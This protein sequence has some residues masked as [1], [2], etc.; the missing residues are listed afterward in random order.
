MCPV[1]AELGSI[2]L[3][4][5]LQSLT[6]SC[7][8][9][10]DA[11]LDHLKA[12]A[13]RTPLSSLS[14][15]Q[16]DM[17]A[18]GLTTILALPA[19]LKA[20]KVLEVSRQ[21]PRRHV[22]DYSRALLRALSHQR[23]SLESLC[24]SL[25]D[26]M[27]SPFSQGF[28]L[29]SFP[30]LRLLKISCQ[31]YN[32]SV[33][34]TSLKWTS[35]APPALDML[36]F[37]GIELQHRQNNVTFPSELQACLKILDPADLCSLAR[38]VCLSLKSGSDVHPDSRK[39]VEELGKRFRTA[40]S[41]ISLASS[42]AGPCHNEEGRDAPRLCVTGFARGRGA[43]PPYLYHEYEPEELPLYDSSSKGTGWL[44]ATGRSSGAPFFSHA[45]EHFN[46]DFSSLE[47]SEVLNDFDF[48]SFLNPPDADMH[49][50]FEDAFL[51]DH[52][53]D[54]AAATWHA[55]PGPVD[56]NVLLSTPLTQ[57]HHHTQDEDGSDSA[58]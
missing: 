4:P 6:I 2:F 35:Y 1:D 27:L 22:L 50:V 18:L 48:D 24:L 11:E 5:N 34:P 9:I 20:L 26:P 58:D 51:H 13:H 33:Y 3:H 56:L 57:M 8:R 52:P 49:A 37:S 39:V 36:V 29:S 46:L 12:F 31:K 40:S 43:I 30:A 53:I 41:Q 32:E 25:R 54:Y 14:L 45:S 55:Q 21:G 16:C 10:D 19:S 28:D 47:D 44:N 23:T 7:A 42:S 38:K 17:S 15:D